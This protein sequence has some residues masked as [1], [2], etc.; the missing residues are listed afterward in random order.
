MRA[1]GLPLRTAIADGLPGITGDVDRLVQVVINLLSNAVKF[2]SEG[3]VDVLVAQDGEALRVEVRDTGRGIPAG[4]HER[5]FDLFRRHSGLL[6]AKAGIT[7][8][9]LEDV[10]LYLRRLERFWG[11][12]IRYIY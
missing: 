5:I 1:A 6:A 12:Q 8:A 3:G 4:D 10:N 9:G 7:V 11:E 2:T